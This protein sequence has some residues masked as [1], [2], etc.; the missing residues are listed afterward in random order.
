MIF[1]SFPYLAFSLLNTGS[2]IA[3]DIG[4]IRMPLVTPVNSKAF[5][6]ISICSN[7]SKKNA[8]PKTSGEIQIILKDPTS[9]NVLRTF[10][11]SSTISTQRNKEIVKFIKAAISATISEFI[12]GRMKSIL[13]MAI[14]SNPLKP[15][16]RMGK[17]MNIQKRP[18]KR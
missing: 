11:F 4:I 9:N 5:P 15:I 3:R 13:G 12:A 6:E 14:F 18:I 17:K 7:K 2:R 16:I 8:V 10:C 1:I